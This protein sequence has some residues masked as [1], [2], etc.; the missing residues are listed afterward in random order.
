MLPFST[1]LATFQAGTIVEELI[2]TGAL[3]VLIASNAAAV[4]AFVHDAITVSA[5]VTS[6]SFTGHGLLPPFVDMLLM[7]L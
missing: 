6:F 1:C 7:A 3:S 5:S 2:T 4:L